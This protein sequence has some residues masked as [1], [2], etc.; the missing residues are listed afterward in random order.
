MNKELV[1]DY[2]LHIPVSTTSIENIEC[3]IAAFIMDTIDLEYQDILKNICVTDDKHFKYFDFTHEG[4]GITVYP[5]TKE[6]YEIIYKLFL[7]SFNKRE[8]WQKER[9]KFLE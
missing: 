9:L 4:S 6:E 1:V 8:E 7:D 3:Y 2:T 5:K